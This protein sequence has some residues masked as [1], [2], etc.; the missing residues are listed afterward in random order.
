MILARIVAAGL[1]AASIA[2]AAPATP[3]PAP[4][5]GAAL[6]R[7]LD[8][9]WAHRDQ[10]KTA[11]HLATLA[12]KD[13]KGASFALLWRLARLHC[14]LADARDPKGHRIPDAT[15]C[16]H[17]GDRATRAA[18]DRPEGHYWAAMGVGLVAEA[19]GDAAAFFLGLGD[20]FNTR[21]DAALRID[22]TYDHCA[23]LLTKADLYRHAPWPVHDLDHAE[24]LVREARKRC[25]ASL[26]PRLYLAEIDLD[27]GHR[28]VARAALKALVEAAAPKHTPEAR[29][30]E[31]DAKADLASLDGG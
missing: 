26:E 21:L 19:K 30:V 29:E 20:K 23:P 8:R 22:P 14:W 25:P 2:A 1:A 13:V 24:R 10:P 17:L 12:R 15:S 31:S 16:W 11:A 6:V 4:A 28:K 18:P 27:R 3:A 9:L 7:T 5:P